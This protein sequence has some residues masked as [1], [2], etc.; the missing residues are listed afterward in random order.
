M[1]SMKRSCYL[2]K[3]SFKSMFLEV[4]LCVSHLIPPADLFPFGRSSCKDWWDALLGILQR[5]STS[6]DMAWLCRKECCSQVVCPFQVEKL[7][8]L[9][10]HIDKANYKRTCSYLTSFARYILLECCLSFKHCAFLQ[11]LMLYLKI[12]NGFRKNCS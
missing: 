4:I 7:E 10:E 11:S 6:K 5:V 2:T 9:I 3:F 8:M 1:Q 12:C